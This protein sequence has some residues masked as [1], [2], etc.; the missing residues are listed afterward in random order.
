MALVLDAS[1]TAALLLPDEFDVATR[2]AGAL[3]SDSVFVPWIWW[4]EVR[5]VLLLAE[6]RGRIE[7]DETAEA[8]HALSALNL[9]IDIDPDETMIFA[10]AR[11]RGITIYD[12]SYLELAIRQQ[13]TLATEDKKLRAAAAAESI[14]VLAV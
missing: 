13:A 10:L 9:L 7:Q 11:S 3:H 4:F 12:A 5:N 2:Y 1:V 6:R 8:L 14:D